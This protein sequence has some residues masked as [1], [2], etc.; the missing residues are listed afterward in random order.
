[1]W[2]LFTTPWAGSSDLPSSAHSPR[3]DLTKLHPQNYKFILTH[4]PDVNLD[5]KPFTRIMMAVP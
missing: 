5:V 4:T 2:R 1:M 3:H